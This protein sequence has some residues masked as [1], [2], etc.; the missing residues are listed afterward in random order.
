MQ[1][2]PITSSLLSAASYDPERQELALTF[3]S[4]ARWVY[5]SQS[6]PFTEQDLDAFTG[7]SSQGQHFLQSIKGQWP[8]RRA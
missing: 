6:R 3:K 7:A 1:S 2:I 8:E 5:G 4:G